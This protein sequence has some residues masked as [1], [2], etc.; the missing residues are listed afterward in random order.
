MI[1]HAGF[2]IVAGLIGALFIFISKISIISGTMDQQISILGTL[3][4]VSV[5]MMGFMLAALAILAS[6]TDKP[7]IKNMANMG[8]FKD[9]LLSLFSACAFY[10]LSFLTASSVLLLGDYHGDWRLFLF[11]SICSD[12]VAT[13][14]IGWKFWKVL[15]NLSSPPNIN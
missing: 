5:S 11:A 4:Q 13:L 10:M 1:L 15:S 8:H 7:L 14:Q 2:T 6:I 12:V 3:A 9:L